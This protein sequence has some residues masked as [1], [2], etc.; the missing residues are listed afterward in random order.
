MS[1]I[2]TIARASSS[3]SVTKTQVPANKLSSVSFAQQLARTAS[4]EIGELSDPASSDFI[5]GRIGLDLLDQTGRIK[6]V[7]Y[8]DETGNK[9]TTSVFRA[10]NILRM[11]EKFGINLDDLRGLAS[12]LDTAG[13]KYKPYEQFQGTGSDA[14][15]D[16]VDLANGGIGTA[17]NWTIPDPLVSMKGE[18]ALKQNTEEMALAARL[19][20]TANRALTTTGEESAAKTQTPSNDAIPGAVVQQLDLTNSTEISELSDP[21]S[22]DFISGRIGLDLLDQTGRIKSVSYYD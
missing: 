11:A 18:Y 3:T 8:Y 20:L 5:S 9:L 22:S 13:I 15:I 4:T 14:G 1:A 16:L 10:P 19:G 6:S 2:Q 17:Y 21:A 12:Q 7:S